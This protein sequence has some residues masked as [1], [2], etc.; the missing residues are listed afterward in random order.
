MKAFTSTLLIVVAAACGGDVGMPAP[1]DSPVTFVAANALVAPV[2]ITVNG[3]QYA[4]LNPGRSTQMTL[5]A[6]A[7]VTWTSAKPAD[8]QGREIADQIGV[9]SVDVPA[10]NS[11]LEFTNIIENQTYFTAR[12]FNLTA[13]QVSIGVFDGSK[14]WCAANMPPATTSGP[15]FIIIG[16]YKLLPATEVRAYTTASDCTGAY[17]LWPQTQLTDFQAKSG[18]L[19]LSLEPSS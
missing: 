16:Y 8:A 19:T 11:T 1:N 18:L 7:H 5:P 14:V 4:I 10:I 9:I 6:N 15:G 2:T 13:S 12:I 17:V 3:E